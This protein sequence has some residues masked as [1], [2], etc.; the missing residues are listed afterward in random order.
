MP[1]AYPLAI[2]DP[3]VPLSDLDSWRWRRTFRCPDG[4]CARQRREA[5][6][7]GRRVTGWQQLQRQLRTGGAPIGPAGRVDPE[8]PVIPGAAYF[9]VE[10]VWLAREL[11]DLPDLPDGTLSF[12]LPEGAPDDPALRHARERHRT[13]HR[14]APRCS[15]GAADWPKPPETLPLVVAAAWTAGRSNSRTRNRRGPSSW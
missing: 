13:W 5:R 8:A 11:T 9:I 4:T 12:G 10:K 14:A 1:G 15:A 3:P 2:F 7:H 6:R